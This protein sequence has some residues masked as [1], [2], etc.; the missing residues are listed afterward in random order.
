V[1]LGFVP[2]NALANPMVLKIAMAIALGVVAIVV[3]AFGLR[4]LRKS[5]LDDSSTQS[6]KSSSKSS[7]FDVTLATY[8]SV[9][10]QFK[11]QGQELERLR[12]QDKQRA[13]TTE[14]ISEAVISNLTSGVVLFSPVGLVQQANPAAKRILGYASPYSLHARDIFRGATAI[15]P[16]NQ[17]SSLPQIL[18]RAAKRREA[19]HRLEVD[20]RTP[21][22]EAR[23][24]GITIS[25][26][27][28]RGG[29]LLGTACLVSDLTEMSNMAQQV[30]LQDNMASLGEMSAGI[31]HEF[32]N[33]LATISGYSQMLASDPNQETREF[34]EKIAL[35]TNN[36]TRIVTDFLNFAR[37][38][39]MQ[40]EP[41]DLRA[42]L[43][44]CAREN[45][46]KLTLNNVPSP[47]TVEADPTALRQVFSNLMRN[48]KEAEAPGK[49]MAIS[50]SAE[51]KGNQ[52]LV[53]IS[54]NG[55]GIPPDKLSKIFIP[56]FTTKA[57]GTGLGL[58]LVHRI[59]TDHGGAVSVT[60]SEA[61]TTFTIS[62]P[63]D[64][65][66]ANSGV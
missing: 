48:S 37:P 43:E 39:G 11:A 19:V 54:D 58:A 41:L 35:E 51:D 5:L 13:S 55:S 61:G 32:K 42:M 27:Q 56:F 66:S 45:S 15:R 52:I 30:R 24:L 21:A 65:A 36:L 17:E 12:Q 20:Y 3:F 57:E 1:V 23:V 31:A 26:V 59:V 46:V 62:L 64:A 18:D 34:A 63:R 22:G 6:N 49:P 16:A 10:Q 28:D 29:A 2:V 9:I 53:R 4:V 14:N 25:P 8:Q 47:C 7:E 33:S 40:R 38:R 50:A 44:D 60:S